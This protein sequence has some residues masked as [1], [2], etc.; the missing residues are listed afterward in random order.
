VK[1]LPGAAEDPRIVAFTDAVQSDLDALQSDPTAIGGDTNPF[2]S[3]QQAAE[4]A[5]LSDCA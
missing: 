4:A 1:A 5:G 3:S 2:E